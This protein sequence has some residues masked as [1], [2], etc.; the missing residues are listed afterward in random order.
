MMKLMMVRM[1]NGN[2]LVVAS[3]KHLFNA[4]TNTE[5]VTCFHLELTSVLV[6][7]GEQRVSEVRL[8]FK[9]PHFSHF[10]KVPFSRLF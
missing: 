7:V 6:G 3:L 8:S 10:I 1:N 2:H 5:V 4:S 9:E